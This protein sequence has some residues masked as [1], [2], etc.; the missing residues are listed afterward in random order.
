VRIVEDKLDRKPKG[1]GYVE[2]GTLDGLKN[3]LALSGSSL[4]G[5]QVRVSV[6]EPRQLSPT[7]HPSFTNNFKPKIDKSRVTLVIGLERAL[8]QTLPVASDVSQIDHPLAVI[9]TSI[10]C[11]MQ[12]AREEAEEL[13]S[14]AMARSATSPTGRER[15]LYLLHRVKP[16]L[17]ATE[18]DKEAKT[19]GSSDETPLL[20]VKADHRKAQDLLGE[21]SPKDPMSSVSLPPRSSTTSGAPR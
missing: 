2:F 11:P 7:N 9:A 17:Y 20:G 18:V 14:K 19:A 3:A 5:R 15:G 21:N 13:S 16:C 8:F 4:A 1:F 10:T 12:E 6:A